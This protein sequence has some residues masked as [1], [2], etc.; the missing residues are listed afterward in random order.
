MKTNKRESKIQATEATFLKGVKGC[1]KLDHVKNADASE[2]LRVLNLNDGQ[3]ERSERVP[4]SRP[5]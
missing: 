1:S 5:A 2:A 3:N 4:G